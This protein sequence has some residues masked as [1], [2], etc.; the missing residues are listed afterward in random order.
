MKP[1][2]KQ[3][4]YEILAVPMG[5]SPVEIN[6]AYQEAFEL[7]RDDSMATY[8]FFSDAERKEILWRLKEAY[9]TLINPESRS[10]YDHTL[11]EMGI[12]EEGKQ[13]RDPSSGPIPILNFQRQTTYYH[14]LPEHPIMEKSLVSENAFIQEIL[15]RDR[16]TGQDL[17]SIRT[18][19]GFPLERIVLQTKVTLGTLQAIEDDRFEL[20]PPP[21]YLKSFLKMY[22]QCL[23]IDAS[24]IIQG[25]MKHYENGK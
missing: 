16:L 3:T 21:V 23:Q 11:T 15:K 20:L 7:Y 22:A 1:Y 5:A 14:R 17:K 6:R 19:L 25:Y 24:I 8:S 9:I 13:Y 12:I 10:G 18:T 2:R 4:H